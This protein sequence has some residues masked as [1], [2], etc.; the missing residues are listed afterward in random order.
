MEQPMTQLDHRY[1]KG[2]HPIFAAICSR[3][4][5]KYIKSKGETLEIETPWHHASHIYASDGRIMVRTATCYLPMPTTASIVELTEKTK[6]PGEPDRLFNETM[7]HIEKT[8]VR[9]PDVK[10]EMDCPDCNGTGMAGPHSD[11]ALQIE[12]FECWGGKVQ[13]KERV[14]LDVRPGGSR[15]FIAAWMVALL[16]SFGAKVYLPHPEH[17]MYWEPSKRSKKGK[18]ILRN[19]AT[20]PFFFTTGDHVEGV[21]MPMRPPETTKSLDTDRKGA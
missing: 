4:E 13:I 10:G 16:R 8:T 15:Y 17:R 21:G 14:D 11:S 20:S 18:I 3:T 7:R 19:E 1:F 9:L 12:C 6:R 5:N 2:L